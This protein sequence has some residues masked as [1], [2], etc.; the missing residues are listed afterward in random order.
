VAPRV[1]ALYVFLA[2]SSD[3]GNA[4]LLST[5]IVLGICTLRLRPITPRLMRVWAWSSLAWSAYALVGSIAYQIEASAGGVV[6]GAY[7]RLAFASL[8]QRVASSLVVPIVT[9]ILLGAKPFREVFSAD[10]FR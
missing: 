8:V 9:L 1:R 6:Q 5:E 7:L 10:A 4:A 3:V 2:I